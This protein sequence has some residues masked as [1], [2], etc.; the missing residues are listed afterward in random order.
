[1]VDWG[2]LSYLD[3]FFVLRW[4]I[5]RQGSTEAY[6][7]Y[8]ELFHSF[9]GNQLN[10]GKL[11]L[12]LGAKRAFNSAG[13]V[14]TRAGHSVELGRVGE[15][16]LGPNRSRFQ[17]DTDYDPRRGAQNKCQLLHRASNTRG[18]AIEGSHDLLLTEKGRITQ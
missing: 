17:P 14:Y 8:D 5:V 7:G 1:M 16:S 18:R 15:T 11:L 3:V 6:G 13:I 10:R 12:F 9:W 2:V 4:R